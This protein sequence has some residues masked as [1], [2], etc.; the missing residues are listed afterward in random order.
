MSTV[1]NK[2][3]GRLRLKISLEDWEPPIW[4]RVEV[5]KDLS[6]WE[7]HRVIQEA[8][9]WEDDHLHEFR[10]A[11]RV[12]GMPGLE[13][14][15]FGREPALP[16][17]TTTLGEL[18]IR[19][20]KFRYWYDFGDDWWHTITIETRLPPDPAAPRAVLVAGEGACPPE[21]C[22]GVYGYSNLLSD[23]QDPAAEGHEDAREWLGEDFDPNHFDLAKNAVR[24]VAVV[25]G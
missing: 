15:L 16:E 4:R 21:N 11:G 3:G 18:L 13:D 5:N 25:G 6:F 22:G 17:D 23:L 14:E 24:V 20:R 2:T 10:A 12:V 7:F 9:G 1:A 8:M 19:Q